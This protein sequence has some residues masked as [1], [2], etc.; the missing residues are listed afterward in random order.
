MTNALVSFCGDYPMAKASFIYGGTRLMREGAV[1]II[2]MADALKTLP[3]LL[4]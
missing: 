2:P 1:D 4:R 3:D